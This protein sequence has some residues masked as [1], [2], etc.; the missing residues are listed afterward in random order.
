DGREPWRSLPLL[1]LIEVRVLP[2]E[3]QLAPI[4]AFVARE[5]LGDLHPAAE[6]LRSPPNFELGVHIELARDIDRR[7]QNVAELVARGLLL[8]LTELVLQ[9]GKRAC[10]IRVL[11]ADGFRALLD[12]A[13]IQEP[14]QALRDVVKDTLAPFLLALDAFPVRAHPLGRAGLDV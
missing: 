10:E 6:A 7:E 14:R 1:R 11:E 2:F 9:I 5:F 13:R 3:R 12:L 4:L 8:E